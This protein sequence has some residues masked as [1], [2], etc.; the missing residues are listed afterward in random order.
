[1]N[2]DRRERI[3]AARRGRASPDQSDAASCHRAYFPAAVFFLNSSVTCLP[4]FDIASSAVS[5]AL[6]FRSSSVPGIF[7]VLACDMIDTAAPMP[8]FTRPDIPPPMPAAPNDE[9]EL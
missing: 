8:G 5:S 4:T 7:I 9:Y 6:Y 1:M 3:A 2:A